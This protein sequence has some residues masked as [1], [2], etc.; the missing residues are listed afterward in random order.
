[1]AQ[2]CKSQDQRHEPTIHLCQARSKFIL[3]ENINQLAR[4]PESCT[5]THPPKTASPGTA[6]QTK[7]NWCSFFFPHCSICSLLQQS[8]IPSMEH[9]PAFWDFVMHLFLTPHQLHF[10]KISFSHSQD[11]WRD[12]GEEDTMLPIHFTPFVPKQRHN[13]SSRAESG[14]STKRIDLFI[15][16]LCMGVKNTG[17]LS[18]LSLVLLSPRELHSLKNVSHAFVWHCPRT[19]NFC[20]ASAELPSF[21]ILGQVLPWKQNFSWAVANTE[22][23]FGVAP[24]LQQQCSVWPKVW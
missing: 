19:P 8:A 1:M 10:F 17:A 18:N 4:Y 5:E 13:H 3:W 12:A 11:S 7:V 2:S 21:M 14:V 24:D 20:S 6:H 23:E 9:F 16:A 22:W 15:S